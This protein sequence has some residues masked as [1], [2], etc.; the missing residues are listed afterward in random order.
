MDIDR[1]DQI[2][3]NLE[4][5]EAPLQSEKAKEMLSAADQAVQSVEAAWSGSWLGHHSRVYYQDL[6]EPPPG[7][8]FSKEWGLDDCFGH[9]T[10]GSWREHR[11]QDVIDEIWSRAGDLDFDDLREDSNA[12]AVAFEDAKCEVQ[13][14]LSPI[15]A[16]CENDKFLTDLAKKIDEMK[17]FTEK[18]FVDFASPKGQQMSRDMVAIHAGFHVPPHI[19]VKAKLFAIR[20]PFAAC[21]D[22]AKTTKR[23]ASHL[24]NL[25]KRTIRNKRLGTNIF[26]GHGRS[27]LWKELK[28]FIQERLHLPWDEFNRVPVAGVTNIARL[29][30]MLDQAAF[31]F[32]IMTAEDEQA[33]GKY[34]A[35]M[36]VVHEAGLFQGRLGFQRAI[37]LLEEGCE[38]FSNIQGLGQIRFPK[39]DVAKV[40]EEIRMVLEREELLGDLDT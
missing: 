12:A 28:D 32:L 37:I 29:S 6:V 5:L 2:A 10:I 13:S 11:N 8:H 40:F 15:V 35:R 25:Q 30:E 23:L 33:G 17:V 34:Q 18:Q 9:G 19:S 4:K 3:A 1:L 21:G 24:S 36:N 22:L 7:A 38:E 26:I 31:A 39:G 16:D 27:K 20:H 14:L